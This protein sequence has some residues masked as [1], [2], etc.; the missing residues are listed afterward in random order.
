[1]I[2]PIKI[3]PDEKTTNQKHGAKGAPKNMKPQAI[4]KTID[5]GD[6]KIITLETGV[7]A[8][9]ADGAVTVRLLSLIHIS[10]PTRPY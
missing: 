8:K 9:Q 2:G 5:M 4:T 1:M 6:G 7:L 3:G 10:E